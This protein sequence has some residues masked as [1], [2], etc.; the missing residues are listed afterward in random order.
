MVGDRLDTDI[1]VGN[2][3]SNRPFQHFVTQYQK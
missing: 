1:K 3:L 2:K